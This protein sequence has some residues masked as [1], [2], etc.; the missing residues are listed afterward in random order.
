MMKMRE[1]ALRDALK[2]RCGAF[3]GMVAM[4]VL[5]LAANFC[6]AGESNQAGTSE[7][8]TPGISSS[9]D[10]EAY[11]RDLAARLG[12]SEGKE[13]LLRGTN[14][15]AP[16]AATPKAVV[17]K[18][19]ATVSAPAKP[20]APRPI[21]RSSQPTQLALPQP[22][23][24]ASTRTQPVWSQPLAT[25]SAPS[26]ELKLFEPNA[27]A[28]PANPN[29]AANPA[30]PV[31][32]A[33]ETPSNVIVV[34]DP[35]AVIVRDPNVVA[36]QEPNT[37]STQRPPLDAAT[38]L[39]IYNKAAEKGLEDIRAERVAKGNKP[40][41]LSSDLEKYRAHA[42]KD[43][44]RE[45]GESLLKAL[46][47]TGMAIGDGVN[48]FMLGYASDRAQ[49]F[50]A[51]DG[52]GLLDEPGKV[53]ATA[54]ATIGSFGEGLYSLA[55][56]ITLNALPDSNS[57]AY[58]DNVPIV[59]PI[60]FAGRTVGGIWKT[61]EEVGNAVTWGFFD[62]VT[63]CIGLLIED[64][65]EVLKHTGEAV[66]NVARLPIRALGAKDEN[67]E[68][69]MDWVLLVPIELVSNSAEMKGIS[70]TIDYKTAFADKGV[71]GSIVEFGG[72]SFIL[73][74]AIDEAAD[75]MKDDHK[76]HHS[77]SNNNNNNGGGNSGGGGGGSGGGVTPGVPDDAV[78]WIGDLWEWWPAN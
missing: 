76:D 63:G 49:A 53:P 51:N 14:P 27:A 23:A 41:T 34:R 6:V 31:N 21:V 60:I 67:S 7:R 28:A 17:K 24:G 43:G 55:D 68:K 29:T 40:W 12:S 71:I 25:E 46:E 73:Y 26:Q 57:S 75:K 3:G 37:A 11:M 4:L 54:G 35:E 1:T 74:R 69:A 44:S 72:S 5:V 9:Q 77:S 15:A 22:Q 10:P 61:T 18:P 70:N 50:R 36:V 56:L 48:V 58:K 19:A 30:N 78:I 62:N 32:P 38:W 65:V 33:T 2:G 39:S 16:R 13:M 64:I 47:R 20:V 52:K 45:S 59:R 8:T 42:V 66:T